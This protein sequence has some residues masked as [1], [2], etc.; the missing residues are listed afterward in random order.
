[1][2]NWQVSAHG[3]DVMAV[4]LGGSA[5][6]EIRTLLDW[7]AMGSWTDRQL[8]TQLPGGGEGGEAALR[9]LIQRHAPMVMGICRRV[10]G[11][12]AAAEDA[13]QATF[14]VLVRKADSL[15]SHEMITNWMY[16]VALRTARNERAKTARRRHVERQGA[17]AR[18]DWPSEELEKAKVRSVIDEELVKLPER[19]RV[20]VILC[21]LEGLRHEE[22]AQRLGCP[23][24]TV[25]S[26]L[27]RARAQLRDRLTRRGL[28]PTASTLA[29]ALSPA[30]ATASMPLTAIAARTLEAAGTLA[31]SRVSFFASPARWLIGRVLSLSP[32][33]RTVAVVS[34]LVISA[35]GL[36]A[37]GFSVFGGGEQPPA[38]PDRTK[39]RPQSSRQPLTQPRTEVHDEKGKPTLAAGRFKLT[40]EGPP[41]APTKV[42][43]RR[44]TKAN[45]AAKESNDDGSP[46]VPT[47]LAGPEVNEPIRSSRS[48]VAYAPPLAGITIDGRLD[49]WPV[50]IARYSIDKLLTTN[51]VGTGGLAGTNLSTSADLSAAFSIGYDPREQ[52]LYLGVI[53]RDDKTV[54]GHAGP[55]DTDALEIYVDGLVSNRQ[56]QQGLSPEEF[57]K[58]ELANVPVQQYIA[59]PG[60][61]MIY[62]VKQASNPILIAGSLKNTKSRMAYTQKGDVTTYEWAIQVFD[63]Y[64]DK[65]TRL[66]PGKRIGF[67]IGVVDRDT[68]ETKNEP[69]ANFSAWVFWSPLWRGIKVLDAGALGE[70]I[71]MK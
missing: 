32:A 43:R 38:Q 29:V 26:R 51:G 68:P 63:R 17:I 42:A 48:A 11:D 36:S 62:G 16:G 46:P 10:L 24:G 56:M 67:D 25:E 28:S 35:A 44:S 8:L 52:L 47:F 19:Y 61:G 18:S 34:A 66:E 69:E 30:D 65:P 41:Q 40:P 50:A 55:T 4:R 71:L 33:L 58:L 54:I 21:Y 9:V 13:F 53:V 20:P 2:V 14:L 23:L 60:K 15:R 57:D 5:I 22:I 6:R 12:E 45:N 70:V 3:G 39:S 49:D 37:A 1:M 7:G 64:P 27:S 31:S 59:I